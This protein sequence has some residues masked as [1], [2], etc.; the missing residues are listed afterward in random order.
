MEKHSLHGVIRADIP[1]PPAAL[2]ARLA[3]HDTAKIADSMAGYGVAHHAIKP[4]RSEMRLCGPAVTVLTRPGD[5][6]YVQKVIEHLHA[7]DIVV[8]DAAGYQDVAVIGERLAG[9]MKLKGAGGIVVD[10][11]VRDSIGIVA[12]GIATFARSCCIRIFGSNGPGAINVP[13]TCGGVA[14]NPG[15]LVCGDADGIV[16]VPH[17]DVA[18][19]ADLADEHL[20]GELAR[21]R[22]VEAGK[23]FGEVFGLQAKLDRWAKK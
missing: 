11:A 18:R 17:G 6:L 7:G 21:K 14:V 15:D 12:E 1:R 10:G 16:I 2:V 5:A 22:E 20:A 19:I 8:I 4:L 9:Y 23:P 13:V 3:Q